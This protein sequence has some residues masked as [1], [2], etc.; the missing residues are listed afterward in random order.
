M[1]D[2]DHYE[3]DDSDVEAA[4]PPANLMQTAR[5][6]LARPVTQQELARAW[7]RSNHLPT[8]EGRVAACL[9][10]LLSDTA[11]SADASREFAAPTIGVQAPVQP[12]KSVISK[13]NRRRAGNVIDLSNDEDMPPVRKQNKRRRP[14]FDGEE[15]E[16]PASAATGLDALNTVHGAER[17]KKARRMDRSDVVPQWLLNQFEAAAAEQARAA[18]A[19]TPRTHPAPSAAV[20]AETQR[21]QVPQVAAVTSP[22][23]QASAPVEEPFPLAQILDI[24][25]DVDLEHVHKLISRYSDNPATCV[26]QVIDSLLANKSYPKAQTSSKT[27]EKGKGNAAAEDDL[28]TRLKAY[29]D[30]DTRARK[31]RIPTYTYREA[32]YVEHLMHYFAIADI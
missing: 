12:A 4:L 20:Q 14:S 23:P 27:V 31:E 24:I 17:T 1:D 21:P 5:H 16:D 11:G 3:L 18:T 29:L 22:L 32:A 26:E 10:R 15:L 13:S 8:E 30:K 2:G 25:P 6:I 7:D 28:L 19:S 9:D